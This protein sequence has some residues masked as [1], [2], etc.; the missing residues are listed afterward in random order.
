MVKLLPEEEKRPLRL[1]ASA[2][3]HLPR[4]AVE[5]LSA[6]MLHRFSGGAVAEGD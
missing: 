2:P 6:T 4:C 1:G 3:I 5:D